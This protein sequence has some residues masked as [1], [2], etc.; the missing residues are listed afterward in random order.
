MTIPRKGAPGTG[1]VFVQFADVAAS[2][3]AT[4]SLGGRTFDGKP[5]EVTYFA[6]EKVKAGDFS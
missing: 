2:E 4:K 1:K 6:E 5:V 3:K